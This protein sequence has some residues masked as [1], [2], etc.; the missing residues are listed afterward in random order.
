MSAE[1]FQAVLQAR[2]EPCA[3]KCA[4]LVMAWHCNAETGHAWPSVATIARECSVSERHAKRAMAALKSAGLLRIVKPSKGGA[5]GLTTVYAF[6][7]QR[8]AELFPPGRADD[9]GAPRAPVSLG[10]ESNPASPP[11]PVSPIGCRPRPAASAPVTPKRDERKATPSLSLKNTRHAPAQGAG[12][13]R[14]SASAFADAPHTQ[15]L[16]LLAEQRAHQATKPP[17]YVR[18]LLKAKQKQQ[19]QPNRRLRLTLLW[20]LVLYCLI[21]VVNVES[22]ARCARHRHINKRTLHC[23]KIGQAHHEWCAR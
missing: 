13:S 8:L 23:H 4:A 5:R 9:T 3:V 1:V 7:L 12:M 22:A 11:A 6:D 19:P 14:A 20:L 17:Q 10:A 15:T 21:I 2:I 18:D 16:R